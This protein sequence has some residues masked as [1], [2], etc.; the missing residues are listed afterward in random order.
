MN[1]NTKWAWVVL[2][3]TIFLT[4][5]YSLDEILGWSPYSSLDIQ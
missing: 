5:Y 2:A 1:T 3:I 4:V